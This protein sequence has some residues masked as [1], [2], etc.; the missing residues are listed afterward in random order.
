MPRAAVQTLQSEGREDDGVHRGL[1]TERNG[2]A[3]RSTHYRQ[4]TAIHA[5]EFASGYGGRAIPDSEEGFGG[6]AGSGT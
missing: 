1:Q 5:R 6:Y 2:A 3:Q 4:E